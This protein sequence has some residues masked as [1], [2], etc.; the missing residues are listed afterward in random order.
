MHVCVFVCIVIYSR[1]QDLEV[2]EGNEHQGLLSI[3]CAHQLIPELVVW[4][5]TAVTDELRRQLS[6][7]FPTVMAERLMRRLAL[8]TVTFG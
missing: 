6:D 5:V 7:C 4:L 2:G 8:E 3:E 1:C